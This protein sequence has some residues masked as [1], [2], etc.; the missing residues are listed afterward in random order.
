[1]RR[2]LK[3]KPFIT[4]LVYFMTILNRFSITISFFKMVA[5]ELLILA[6]WSLIFSSTSSN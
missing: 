1:M 4:H 2:L 6:S 5:F 3:E